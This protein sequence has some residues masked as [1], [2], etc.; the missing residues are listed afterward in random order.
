VPKDCCAEGVGFGGALLGSGLVADAARA[1]DVGPSRRWLELDGGYSGPP[2]AIGAGFLHALRLSS[3]K[4][5]R[6]REL[7]REPA[8]PE[9]EGVAIRRYGKAMRLWSVAW[10]LPFC[11][12]SCG[13]KSAVSLSVI[14][15]QATIMAQ[16]GQLGATLSGGFELKFELGPEASGPTTVTLGSFALQTAT[17]SALFDPLTFDA[18]NTV[19]PL[20]VSQGGKRTVTFTLSSTKLLTP[21]ERDAL[22]AG[23]VQIV[24]SVMDSLSGGTDAVTSGPI[25]P[26]CQ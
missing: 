3:K 4:N 25:T 12:L 11:L 18:G 19:F 16:S 22:C 8:Y 7:T 24:G 21:D 2:G 20:V 9:V 6:H 17:G 15:D 1:P 13:D 10:A 5:A 14:L 23:P 26:T